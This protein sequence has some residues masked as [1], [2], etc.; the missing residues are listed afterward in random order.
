LHG[1]H[2]GRYS[3]KRKGF[4]FFHHLDR[5]TTPFYFTNFPDNVKVMDLWGLFNKFGRVG[6]VYIPN[7]LDK[8]GQRFGFVKFKEVSNAK[9]LEDR[10]GDVW[11][12][13]FKLRI[14]LSRFNRGA[15]ESSDSK[16]Q[17]GEGVST[18]P[19][20]PL[21][22]QRAGGVARVAQG[23]SYRT[24]LTQE[25]NE[26]RSTGTIAVHD[27][28]QL[29][30]PK[31]LVAK[32]DMEHLKKLETSYVGFL[33]EEKDASKVSEGLILEGYDWVK[34]TYMG[35]NM[36]LSIL[37][38]RSVKDAVLANQKWWEGWFR[39]ILEWSLDMFFDRRVVWLRCRGVPLHAWDESLFSS[40]AKKFGMFI[41]V[42]GTTANHTKLDVAR[43]KISTSRMAFIDMDIMISVLDKNYQI[44][45][46]EEPE[47]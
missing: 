35:G 12:D 17:R 26:V 11:W 29:V 36:L 6:E 38:L 5:I 31:V 20:E 9:E 15:K 30:Q 46:V 42:D 23:K 39:S 44:W 10:L 22:Q 34:A 43:V 28:S 24:A 2:G 13:S 18:H 3:E 47:I 14:N 25:V 4:G 37:S 7:K 8:K 41:E 1:D 40:V 27:K 45:V 16:V 32:V 19:K 33:L 21:F